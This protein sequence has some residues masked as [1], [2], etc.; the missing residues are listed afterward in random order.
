[1]VQVRRF[2]AA[3]RRWPVWKAARISGSHCSIQPAS[4]YALA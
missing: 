1:V 3:D 4:V 2:L